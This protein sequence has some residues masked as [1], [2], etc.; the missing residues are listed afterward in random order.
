VLD[1]IYKKLQKSK[2][3]LIKSGIGDGRIR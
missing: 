1:L 3:K 2:K